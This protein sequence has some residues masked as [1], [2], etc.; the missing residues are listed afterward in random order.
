M[1]KTGHS[2]ED[3]VYLSLSGRPSR[4]GVVVLAL[5][6]SLK[7][8]LH[9]LHLKV[10]SLKSQSL[11][12]C[13][14]LKWV[15]EPPDVPAYSVTALEGTLIKNPFTSVLFLDKE[16]PTGNS[17]K[18]YFFFQKPMEEGSHASMGMWTTFT[19]SNTGCLWRK[20]HEDI[21]AHFPSYVSESGHE[22]RT[23]NSEG[24]RFEVLFWASHIKRGEVVLSF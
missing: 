7:P 6:A 13:L 14:W 21:S 18:G 15:C 22:S 10:C 5:R 20:H 4:I 17:Y 16:I 12:W 19:T 1:G 8:S 9:S 3:L 23:I 11:N 2:T 24:G